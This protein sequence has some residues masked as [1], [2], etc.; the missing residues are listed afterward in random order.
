MSLAQQQQ[1]Q[2]HRQLQHQAQLAK[3]RVPPAPAVI[4][5][6]RPVAPN[7]VKAGEQS[8]VPNPHHPPAAASHRNHSSVPDL[9]NNSSP[10]I[11][12]PESPRAEQDSYGSPLALK[13]HQLAVL[14][15]LLDV[16]RN[17]YNTHKL[18][19][20]RDKA[21]SG[22]TFCVL[23][24]MMAEKISNLDL[25]R[26]NVIIVPLA[27]HSQWKE[28]IDVFN[29]GAE[30]PLTYTDFTEYA[31]VASLMHGTLNRYSDIL[32]TTPL[33]ADTIL[34]ACEGARIAVDR[35]V[36]DEADSIE[37]C[38]QT[39]AKAGF[40]WFVSA[41]F[42]QVPRAYQQRV[43]KLN[44]LQMESCSVW[45]QPEFV[46][47][48]WNLPVP[49]SNR[50]K[51]TSTYVDIVMRPLLN[52]QQ[53]E[54][55]NAGDYHCLP[56]NTTNKVP[57]DDKEAVDVMIETCKSQVAMNQPIIEMLQAKLKTM[58][59][60]PE[61][62]TLAEQLDDT[63]KISEQHQQA[64]DTLTSGLQSVKAHVP[65]NK[66]KSVISVLKQTPPGSQAIVYC[67]HIQIF[68]KLGNMLREAGIKYCQLDAGT[69]EE[70]DKVIARYKKGEIPV[71]LGYAGIWAQGLNLENTSDIIF[72][73]AMEA[74][75]EHQVV[76]RG[77]RAGRKDSLRV[78]FMCFDNE[79]QTQSKQKSSK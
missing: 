38:I 4:Q 61:K 56:Y 26:T 5:P 31:A 57:Q 7:A 9:T 74:S 13:P 21:G 11:L 47:T 55:V 18:G 39:Q 28:A 23:A 64:L 36:F 68:D 52:P 16:E 60:H 40:I 62:T 59:N 33:Y 53:L 30:H 54:Q 12:S 69:I 34:N 24:L 19:I 58:G 29:T 73:H 15:R 75:L 20:L 48:V 65:S 70:I 46:D 43:E 1:Y 79:I 67:K 14:K 50:V 25:T 41:S 27:I 8:Q 2:R 63:K 66:L 37:W 17:N 22:K 42:K 76:G 78:W 10:F 77:Q 6:P 44:R 71:F 45:C 51:C 3:Q 35:V 49:K 72:M 32:I